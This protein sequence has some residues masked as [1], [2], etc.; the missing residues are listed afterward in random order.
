V[1]SGGLLVFK[2]F[3]KDVI[4]W[5]QENLNQLPHRAVQH[6]SREATRIARSGLFSFAEEIALGLGEVNE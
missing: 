2:F 4:N 5:S 6:G 3:L 1:V